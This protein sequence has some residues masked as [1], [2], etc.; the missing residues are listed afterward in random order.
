LSTFR[1]WQTWTAYLREHPH[2]AFVPRKIADDD[3]LL[4]VIAI[5][6]GKG[7]DGEDASFD[8]TMYALHPWR[9]ARDE[10]TMPVLQPG[11]YSM[12]ETLAGAQ[13]LLPAG[14]TLIDLPMV[15]G[16]LEAYVC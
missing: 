11:P 14:A 2:D 4:T 7:L 8:H 13:A 12:S 16:Y 10:P 1:L 5:R 15:D 6:H 9:V 3:A